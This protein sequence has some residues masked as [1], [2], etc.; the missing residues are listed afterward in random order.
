M[1]SPIKFQKLRKIIR[2]TDTVNKLCS[3]KTIEGKMP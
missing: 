3:S 2:E 1:I